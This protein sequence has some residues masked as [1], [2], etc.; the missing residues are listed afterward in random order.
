MKKVLL[1]A[2]LGTSICLST[3]T[4]FAQMVKTQDIS[5]QLQTSLEASAPTLVY[6]DFDKDIISP[7]AANILDQQATWLLSNSE[8]KVDLAGHTDA[9]GTN[10]YNDDLAMRRARAVEAYLLSRGVS[11]AQMRSV[12]SRGESNLLVPTTKRER[13]NRRVSTSVTG[14]VEIVEAMP[15]LPAPP[16]IAPPVTRTYAK[17]RPLTCDGRSRTASLMTEDLKSIK[18][19]LQARMNAAANRYNDQAVITNTS[20]EY[21]LAAFTKVECGKAIGYTKKSIKDERSI[22]NCYCYSELLTA[23]TQ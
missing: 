8:A 23:Q 19:D 9:I 5:M 6:F 12:V 11:A 17:E 2:L 1:S 10:E 13:L 16:A 4:A 21:N 22:S 14:L 18:S 15:Q 20:S 7:E 3:S